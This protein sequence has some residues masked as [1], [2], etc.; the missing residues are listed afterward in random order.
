MSPS[1]KQCVTVSIYIESSIVDVSYS[2]NFTFGD[3]SVITFQA[4]V[5]VDLETGNGSAM[6]SFGHTEKRSHGTEDFT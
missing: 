1:R 3:G 6:N 2:S 5:F 4:Q